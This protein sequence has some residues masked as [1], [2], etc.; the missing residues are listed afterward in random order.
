MSKSTLQFEEIVRRARTMNTM[1][2]EAFVRESCGDDETLV[3][4]VFLAIADQ[5][6]DVQDTDA[7]DPRRLENER[8]GPY[9]IVRLIGSGGMGDVYL[10][11]RADEEYQQRVAIKVVRNGAL[12]AQ[13]QARLR[14]ERQIL[15][16]LQHPNIARLLDGGRTADGRPYL[17][18]EYIEGEP[19]D[20]YC[21]RRRLSVEARL[22]V[23]KAVCAA[24]QYAHRNLIVHRDLKP[25]NI[26]ITAD[27]TPKL[28]DF[29]IAKLLDA[30]HTPRT[31]AM[32]HMDY[33]MMTPAHASPEQVRGD[34]ITTASDI[35]VLGV[36]LYELLCGRRPFDLVGARLSD[37][38]RIICEQVPVTPSARFARTQN[39]SS[40]LAA[41][42]AACR[43]TTPQRLVKNLR[44]D[45]DHVVM[46]AMR[47]EVERRYS[48]V[49]QLSEDID[50]HLLGLP[51]RATPARWTYRANKFVRRN[52][53]SVIF[54][55]TAVLLLIAFAVTTSM[56]SSRLAHERDIA[57]AERLR[58]EQVSSFLVELFE[59]SDPS[60]S[61]G[62]E[63][64]ARE[65]LDIG[66]RRV[67][68]GL[69]DQPHTRAMLLDTIGRVYS[70][71]GLYP[72]SVRLLE[73]SLAAL[74]RLHGPKHLDIARAKVVLG[75]AY[76]DQ[77]NYAQAQKELDEALAIQR[78]LSG[79]ATLDVARTLVAMGTLARARGIHEVAQEMYEQSLALYRQHGR[80]RDPEVSSLLNEMAGLHLSRAESADAE[81]LYRTALDIDRHA[82][83]QDHPQVAMHLVNLALT[84]QEQ[85]KLP[86]AGPV[87]VQALQIMNRV[88]GAAHPITLDARANYGRFLH[89][90]G[91]WERAER[92]LREVLAT[93][94]TAR[95]P[96]HAYVGHDHANL[97]MLLLDRDDA[98]GAHREF[99]AALAI[100][101]QSLDENH[102]FI[103]TALSGLG[104]SLNAQRKWQAAEMH[105]RKAADIGA[106]V[107]E[108]DS[109]ALAVARAELGYA[110]LAQG[111]YAA[112]RALLEPS[113][114]ILER[115]TS[116]SPRIVVRAREA[117]AQAKSERPAN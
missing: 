48:S 54:A 59:L 26:L 63:V 58:A 65:L 99:E 43:S 106:E 30:R 61:R 8:L 108:A 101:R 45:L 41:D 98:A 79:T 70:S 105:L 96:T 74:V 14:M 1:E 82:L 80:E 107:F 47:K 67:D 25:N 32:T 71:L 76:T 28:L 55:S 10:A 116:I 24:V 62:E 77:G 93:N 31:I 38:E 12:S 111:K 5:V 50:R 66:A 64:T 103:A 60:R 90:S 89:R 33:R 9:R 23:F 91:E 20:S 109:R 94:R 27:G 40:E 87:Y 37:L 104:Q 52:W 2:R 86:E 97:G 34:T 110:L 92:E 7:D 49:E 13:I 115:Q 84:L 88:L 95:G 39:D 73:E 69:N 117:L 29:G 81:R 75:A 3:S 22:H 19:I 113:V 44:G 114:P 100:Y 72:E 46:L 17:V 6:Q 16:S 83:G 21:D 112:A 57:S 56:Q 42:I 85:G 18:M 11:D 4:Q 68:L 102:P 78:E 51:V 15:A 36:L 35:Y 53:V